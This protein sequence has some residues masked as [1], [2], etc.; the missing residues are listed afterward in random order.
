ML[1]RY[2]QKVYRFHL[3]LAIRMGSP[4]GASHSF[5]ESSDHY[6]LS[7]LTQR[8][9]VLGDTIVISSLIAGPTGLPNFS[10]GVA[11]RPSR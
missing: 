10:G 4:A 11:P 9:N 8:E 3:L 5:S 2:L 1:V 7:T 6:S